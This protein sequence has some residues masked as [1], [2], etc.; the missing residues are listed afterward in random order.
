MGESSQLQSKEVHLPLND[1]DFPS[2]ITTSEHNIIE[3][4][5]LPALER[6][7]K[8]DRG[9]GYFSSG[10]FRIAAKGMASFSNNGGHARWV[11]SPILDED[12]WAAMLKGEMAIQDILLYEILKKNISELINSLE[13]D[14]LSAIA[15]M[16]ADR[17]I[18]F[19]LALPR[20]KLNHGEFHDKFGIFYDS[21]G[22]TLVFNGSYNDSI[23]GTLNYESI[24]LFTSWDSAAEK[25]I[26]EDVNRF[27]ALWN[28]NDP[29]VQVYDL[30][31]AAKEEILKLR[32]SRRPFPIAEIP[33]PYNVSFP[34]RPS[35]PSK[36]KIRDY[37]LE[38][39]DA[40]FNA[41]CRGLFEMATGTGKTIT[42]LAA[43]IKLLE[44]EKR[45]VIIVACPYQHLVDQ[46]VDEAKEFGYIPIKAYQSVNTWID[47]VNE[48]ILA[49]NHND[50]SSI[51]I[52]TTHSSFSTDN[53]L[54]TVNRIQGPI[55]IIA[56]ESHHLGSA[57]Q[58]DFLPQTAQY[59]LA[60][61]ATPTRW[62]DAEGTNFLLD[63]FGKIVYSLSLT[64]AIQKGFLTPYYYYPILVELTDDEMIEYS[65]LSSKIGSLIA[66]KNNSD[67]QEMLER[68]LIKR[69]NILNNATNKIVEVSRLINEQELIF[70]TLFYCAPGQID[71]VVQL[72]GW[73]NG[74]RI[75]R[76]TA[77]EDIPTRRRLLDEF[78][79][80]K[81]QALVAMRCLDE[82]VDVPSTRTAYILASSSNPRE[83]IQRRGRILRK[84]PGKESAII[85]DLIAVPPA[86]AFSDQISFNAEKSLL[87][88]E[89]RR[90]AE[91]ADSSLNSQAA[92]DVIW[93]LA[94]EFG[95]LGF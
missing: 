17:T 66:Q 86:K 65:E 57:R 89:L 93:E 21:V 87:K 81:L 24:K 79:N 54:N 6:S 75:H 37:Q 74:L 67:V 58:R 39:I 10:W 26:N 18:E 12:D 68:L 77:H 3:D 84:A 20:N 88:R 73:K 63:Y 47:E 69:A 82:G 2:I 71:E 27:E 48:R 70:H 76:F 9:V 35:I 16:I 78:A 40:W 4:F 91:F 38:A 56:D 51:C 92:Y 43:S 64:E 55:L 61:S 32:K 59:R 29:N 36:I 30:P 52:I 23:Q 90:F 42:A 80:E 46:W 45:L 22:N 72:L 33:K 14:T 13:E 60:L 41:D 31:T 50:I 62:Y 34:V 53:F 11:T 95:I 49:F 83:F 8:Y 94:K 25:W 44:R 5:F 85:Y 1:F 15:W 28:N 19:K 7:V